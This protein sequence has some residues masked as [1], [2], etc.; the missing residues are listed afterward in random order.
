MFEEKTAK[1][2][3]VETVTNVYSKL[4]KRNE[5]LFVV[6]APG[7]NGIREPDVLSNYDTD[8][9]YYKNILGFESIKAM[10]DSFVA[11][12]KAMSD[13][14][15]KYHGFYIGRYELTGTVEKPTEKAGVVLTE[16]DAGNWYYLYKAC[17]N[18][19]KNNS[20]VKSMM[21]WGCQYD[22]TMNWLKNTIF[23]GQEDKVD[24]DSSSWGHYSSSS[25]INTGSNINYKVN[26]IFDLA[27]NHWEW[28]Q[29]AWSTNTR[30]IRGGYFGDTGTTYPASDRGSG[31]PND[32]TDSSDGGTRATLYIL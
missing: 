13:S 11:E 21:I 28:T 26:E 10:A 25:K 8:S 15:K 32:G 6:E 2:T 9:Q 31:Y 22:E 29:E 3:G 20:S 27:G 24:V 30:I 12:Y 17:H 14:I 5:D 4:R 19:I 23:K 7:T 16:E 1:L 18:V